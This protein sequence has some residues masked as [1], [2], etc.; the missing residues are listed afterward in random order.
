MSQKLPSKTYA[1]L[2]GLFTVI[3]NNEVDMLS[4]VQKS[5]ITGS[6]LYDITNARAGLETIVELENSSESEVT[7]SFS[8]LDLKEEDREHKIASLSRII[9]KFVTTNN[10]I[11]LLPFGGGEK[12]LLPG[13]PSTGDLVVT[14]GSTVT[15][16]AGDVYSYTNLTV[17]A[18]GILDIIDYSNSGNLTEIYA[19]SLVVN[20]T[21]RA[22][23]LSLTSDVSVSH[24]TYAGIELSYQYSLANGGKGGNANFTT[25]SYGGTGSKSSGG[26]GAGGGARAGYSSWVGGAGGSN[27]SNGSDAHSGTGGAGGQSSAYPGATP[28]GGAGA[29]GG[30]AGVNAISGIYRS[31]GGGGGG[32]GKSGGSGLPLFLQS[33]NPII[34]TG[35]IDV[36][37]SQGGNG[38]NG[39]NTSHGTVSF[40]CGICP[41]A[42]GG[43]GA[44]GNGGHLFISSV[45][46]SVT[47]NNSNAGGGCGGMQGS[48][49]VYYQGSIHAATAGDG[50]SDGNHGTYLE[51]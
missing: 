10:E 36:S 49:T 44:G 12:S 1:E 30:G 25:V 38:A 5:R 13:P 22:R 19:E 4:N 8:N 20:G 24:T 9:L 21:I 43:G 28:N 16:S 6:Q 15:L 48:V 37:G 32:A 50:G 41:G 11:L 2:K 27:G 45:S 18:G 42:G 35:I 51:L 26:G 31:T 46:S 7:I 3:T 14:A 29:S 17:D 23:G 40:F 47:F 39:G 34:G 33:L